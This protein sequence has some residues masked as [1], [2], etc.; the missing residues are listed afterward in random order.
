MR[1]LVVEISKRAIKQAKNEEVPTVTVNQLEIILHQI[2]R[3]YTQLIIHR[4]GS[5]CLLKFFVSDARFSMNFIAKF[6]YTNSI[7]K[8]QHF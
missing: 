6:I 5:G 7:I 8:I 1:I 4:R 2:V 3:N